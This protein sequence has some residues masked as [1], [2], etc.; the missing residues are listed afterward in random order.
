MDLIKRPRRLR[1]QSS[2]RQL[3]QE[4]QLS[5]TDLIMPVF[6]KE[7]IQTKEPIHTLPGIYRHS[8]A[9]A[10]EH[11]KQ[12][13][14]VGIL[15][16]VLFVCLLEEKKSSQAHEALNINNCYYQAIQAIKEACPNLLVITDVALDPYSSDGHDG[17]VR[18]GQ[19]V[20]DET[21]DILAK[22]SVLQARAGADIVAPS[23]MMDGRVL[24][25]RKALDQAHCQHIS[26]LSYTAKYASAFYGPFRDA[27]DSAPKKG[28]KKSYQMN[29]ANRL[30][31]LKE[32]Q[33]DEAEGADML[34]VKPASM[35]LDVLAAIKQQTHLPLAAYHVS[36]EYS[37]LKAAQAKGYI[38]YEQALMEVM[39]SIKRAGADFILT[40]AAIELAYLLQ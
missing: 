16:I 30:E 14:D 29:V 13:V 26:I 32:A 17:I 39:L 7:G 31:A 1:Y 4:T 37:M 38:N 27:L 18:N 11:C 10:V 28:D 2:I 23:D 19:I 40:Y 21:V 25:I 20:N 35:Y 36:G 22:M 33:L 9:S 5:V 12:L 6:V 24:A 15:G 8:I 3:V 34:M